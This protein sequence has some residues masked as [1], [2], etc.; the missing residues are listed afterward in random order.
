M[1][2]SLISSQLRSKKND[3]LSFGS[4]EYWR[5]IGKLDGDEVHAAQS[6]HLPFHADKIQSSTIAMSRRVCYRENV[7]I[8]YLLRLKY[9]TSLCWAY[10]RVLS[11]FL[12]QL[13]TVNHCVCTIQKWQ[14]L[15]KQYF[16]SAVFLRLVTNIVFSWLA[17]NSEIL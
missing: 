5:F 16:T 2:I 13:I 12:L 8:L 11:P 14:S 17:I 3:Q 1:V 9:I 15:L 4:S 10:F 6:L 7:N